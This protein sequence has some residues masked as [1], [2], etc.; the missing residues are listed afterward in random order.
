MDKPIYLG[1]AILELSKLLMFE[2][3]YHKL[4]A[5]F[6]EKILQFFYMDS[7]TK[8]IPIILKIN[9]SIKILRVDEIINEEAW[10][11]DDNVITQLGYR[12]FCDCGGTQVCTSGGWKNNEIVGHKTE[13]VNYRIRTKHGIVDVTGDHSLIDKN[14]EI[15]KPC[16]LLLVEEMLH[17]HINFGESKI[18]LDELIDKIYNIETET[19]EEKRRFVEGFFLGDGSSGIYRYPSGIKFCWHLNSLDFNLIEKLQRYCKE[20]WIDIIFK[21]YNVIESSQGYR[22][23]S[24]KKKLAL[25][26][27]NF[28]T[29]EKRIP[30]YMLNETIENRKW[31]LLGFYS[32][33][34]SKKMDK[35]YLFFTEK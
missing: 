33:D 5:Y 29:K 6:G 21:V 15:I 9:E 12:E 4:Q 20:V 17:N 34:G 10:Y 3:S 25:Y 23:S 2:T 13:K 35:M 7:V 28:D 22:I 19:L 11:Q 18:T 31:F 14:R 26:F 24:G 16:D 1:F 30:D 32:A 27:D 8:D